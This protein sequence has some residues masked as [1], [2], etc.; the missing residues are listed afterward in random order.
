MNIIAIVVLCLVSIFILAFNLSHIEEGLTPD[1]SSTQKIIGINDKIPFGYYQVSAD[2]A[3][4][5]KTIAAVPYGYTLVGD[6]LY[7]TT[8][9]EKLSQLANNTIFPNDKNEESSNKYDTN[10]YNLYY[11]DD[12]TKVM[13]NDT[14]SDNLAQTGTWVIDK[15]GNKVLMPWSNV[16]NNITYYEPGSYPFGPSN[17]VPNYEDTNYLSKTTGQSQVG[18]YYD[19]PS[20]MGGFCAKLANNIFGLE[21]ACN[22][23]DT[24]T[25]ASTSCCTL[26]GGQKCVAGGINGPSVPANYSNVFIQNKDFYYYQG[27]CYGNCQGN[28][29]L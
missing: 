12:P 8:N 16:K 9:A 23:L 7:P 5:K 2:K 11:H 24:D 20:M 17:Y 6:N 27:K 21:Q 19:I 13:S 14:I 28:S 1:M 25:C 10:N 29:V 15:D 26:L 22:A 3:N 4:N 18:S